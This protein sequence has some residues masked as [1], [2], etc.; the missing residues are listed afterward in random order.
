MNE[1]IFLLYQRRITG[2]HHFYRHTQIPTAI[3][4]LQPH[5]GKANAYQVDQFLNLVNRF[6]LTLQD[7]DDK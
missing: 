7:E 1:I 3:L 2:S 4:N 6:N 5:K